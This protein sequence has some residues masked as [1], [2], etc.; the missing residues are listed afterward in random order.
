LDV[1]TE[2]RYSRMLA[3][4]LGAAA[5]DTATEHRLS[6]ACVV[7]ALTLLFGR[8][9]G[10]V[11]HQRGFDLVDYIEFMTGRVRRVAAAEFFR[12]S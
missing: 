7:R 4:A 11:A 6:D 12:R 1:N 5:S 10:A 3:Q 9:A 8:V 2:G